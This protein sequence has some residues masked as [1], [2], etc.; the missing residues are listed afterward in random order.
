MLPS[1]RL[2]APLVSLSVPKGANA[3]EFAVPDGALPPFYFDVASF[4]CG[5]LP[6][7]SAQATVSDVSV[8]GNV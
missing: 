7:M 2:A 4:G 5:Q 3:V 6:A 8:F 1:G